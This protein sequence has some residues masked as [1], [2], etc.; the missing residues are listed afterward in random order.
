MFDAIRKAIET[1]F[2]TGWNDTGSTVKVVYEGQPADKSLEWMRLTVVAGGGGLDSIGSTHR[3]VRQ[4]GVVILQIFTQKNTGTARARQLADLATPVLELKQITEGA[5]VV[6]TEAAYLRDT[7]EQDTYYQKNLIWP[8][9]A[10]TV[11]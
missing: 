2:A 9:S 1:T 7:P 8:F 4:N 11:K 6:D 3:L 5:V 10:R